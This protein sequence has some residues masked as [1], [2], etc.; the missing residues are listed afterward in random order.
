[1][2]MSPAGPRSF[3]ICLPL[4]KCSFCLRTKQ[5]DWWV[6]PPFAPV[7]LY[8]CHKRE[9]QSAT[10]EAEEEMSRTRS[11]KKSVCLAKFL[12]DVFSTFSMKS[13]TGRLQVTKPERCSKSSFLLS[14]ICIVGTNKWTPIGA[15]VLT[16][17]C[18]CVSRITFK[19][20]NWFVPNL[21]EGWDGG[22]G[23]T[24]SMCGSS[25]RI[26]FVFQLDLSINFSVRGY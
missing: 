8:H 22:Q 7:S 13:G 23:G 1:M 10:C 5:Q 11:P 16:C 18:L 25:S 26:I 21:V 12:F 4:V 9:T 3:D 14:I 19:V 24:H 17:F 2:R 20:L 6:P 15:Y